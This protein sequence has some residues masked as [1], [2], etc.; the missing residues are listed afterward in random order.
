VA[1]NP[2]STKTPSVMRSLPLLGGNEGVMPA[3]LKGSR[4]PL[5]GTPMSENDKDDKNVVP[6]RKSLADEVRGQVTTVASNATEKD[7]NA[8]NALVANVTGAEFGARVETFSPGMCALLFLFHNSHNRPWNPGWTLE[9][10]RRMKTGIWKKN[11]MSA[12]F[13]S[14][15]KLEDGQHRLAAAA[16]A[17]MTWVVALIVGV[18]PGSVDTIDGGRRRSGADHASLDGIQNPTK[19]QAIVRSTAAYFVRSGDSSAALK[20]EAEVK[21]AIEN[22]DALLMQAM[23][24]GAASRLNLSDP[25]LKESTASAIAYVLIKSEWPLQ[26]IREKLAFFQ[27]AGGSQLGENDPFFVAVSLLT[28][29]RAKQ[30][31]GEKLTLAKEMGYVI[32]ALVETEK[33]TRAIT[34]K[35]FDQAVKKSV[36]DPRYPGAAV[37]E[38]AA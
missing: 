8:V 24:I 28:K 23:D 29:M 7:R 25:Q 4:N 37:H 16:I 34:T 36:P 10:A 3:R 18:E 9:L 6:I 11:S 30:A 12:G 1:I 22:N 32:L 17:N 20:S 27:Q 15:G 5:K 2:H 13:Y 19:K 26:I 33:G 35:K 14:N 21:N 38:T 31:R